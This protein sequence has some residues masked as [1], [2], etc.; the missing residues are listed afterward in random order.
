MTAAAIAAT[1]ISVTS[2]D[3]DQL[4]LNEVVYENYWTN[5]DDVE[6]V[7]ASCYTGM[8]SEAYLKSLIVWGELRSDNTVPGQNVTDDGNISN[9]MKG[10]LKTTNSYCDWSP[11]YNVINRCNV[12]LAEAPL[13]AQKDPNYTSSDLAINQ[14]ECRFIR[15]YSYFLLVRTFKNVP[16]SFEPSL[17]DNQNYRLKQTAGELIIDTLIADIDEY[18]DLAANR[19]TNVQSSVGKVTRPAMYALL[20]D[21]YL[22]R[23]SDVNVPK[24]KQ[25]ELYKKCI[26]CCDWVLDYKVKQY[27]EDAYFGIKLK[28]YMDPEVL[29]EYHYPLLAEEPTPGTPTSIKDGP[30]ATRWIFGINPTNNGMSFSYESI[31]ELAFYSSSGSSDNNAV[32]KIYGEGTGQKQVAQ[33][34]DKLFETVPQKDG[35]YS[36]SRLFSVPSDYR[37]IASFYYNEIA[38][39]GYNIYKYAI[40]NNRAGTGEF[41][42]V[43]SEYKPATSTQYYNV[44]QD[45][46]KCFP[47][48]S[49]WVVYRLSEIMLMR[50]EAE[51]ELAYIMN[52]SPATGEEGGNDNADNA[53]EGGSTEETPEAPAEAAKGTRATAFTH[54]STLATAEELYT[55]AYNLISAV[56]RRSN[57]YVKHNPKFAPNKPNTYDGFH[58][59]LMNERRREFLFEAKR[60]FDLVRSA[61]RIGNTQEFRQAMSAKYS[62]ASPAV[63]VKMVQMDFLYMPVL[64]SE[65]KANPELEQNSCYLDEEENL[66]N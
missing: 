60:Y 37:S 43:G 42:A 48:K 7:V 53:E 41:G 18:K 23:A 49:N 34:S 1:G 66:K 55:D 12:T 10:G 33:A 64:K 35:E 6:S 58:T 27:D 14:A 46:I 19:Y 50:A 16:F 20:A 62:D 32:I 24:D 15:A 65:K 47:G 29:K 31:F 2:C 26:E 25:M 3:I 40:T 38:G 13:V 8:M 59:L 17:D 54:G 52:S 11:I 22:W 21:L 28:D 36:D 51:I 9:L 30:A 44:T 63:A 45:N 56:Y 61:R 57:P 4:P 5:K 39:G